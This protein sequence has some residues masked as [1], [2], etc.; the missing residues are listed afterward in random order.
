MP[1]R[2]SEASPLATRFE[3][4]VAAADGDTRPDWLATA[5]TDPV[6]RDRL[7]EVAAVLAGDDEEPATAYQTR[8]SAAERAASGHFTTDPALATALSRWAI[9]PRADDAHPRVLDPAT[10]SGAFTLA[11]HDRLAEIAPDQSAADRLARIVG[12]DVDSIPLAVTA[13]RLLAGA[14]ADTAPLELY[15]ANFF[16]VVPGSSRSCSVTADEVVAGQFDAVV[17]NPPYVRQEHTDIDRAR[18]HLG[19]FGPDGRTP[20]RDGDRALSR[21]S[22]AYVYFVTHATRFLRDGGRLGVVVPARWLTT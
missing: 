4:V 13:H 9:Q 17:G 19:A 21:R 5:T 1:D 20:Y 14:A 8:L 16:D 6:V 3:A 15:E 10:G 11:A 12:I 18:D 7:A 22:D 2:Q